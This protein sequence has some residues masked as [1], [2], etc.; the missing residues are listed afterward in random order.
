MKKRIMSLLLALLMVISV[1]PMPT[2][3]E[4]VT[5]SEELRCLCPENYDT[6]NGHVATCPLYTCP[7]CG[8]APW[9]ET[10]P[11]SGDIG[12]YAVLNSALSTYTAYNEYEFPYY[13]ED[14][15]ADTV[16]TIT[17]WRWD[18]EAKQ[19]WYQVEFYSGS[20]QGSFGVWNPGTWFL[21]NSESGDTL[22]FVEICEICGKP[23]CDGKHTQCGICG[24]YGCTELHFY[25]EHCDNYTCTEDHLICRAC[26]TPD[27]ETA[28][29]WCGICAEYDCGE[30]HVDAFKPVTAPIIPAS[31]AM[32]P[33]AEVS[34]ADENGNAVSSLILAPGQR[35][36]LS[37]WSAKGLSGVYQWQIRYDA[38]EDLWTNIQG[39]TGKGII[40]SPGLVNSVIS[41]SG[42]AALRC[43]ITSGDVTEVS[44]AIPVS[45]LYEPV[46]FSENGSASFPIAEEDDGDLLEDA[47]IVIQYV[48]SDGRTAASSDIAEVIPGVPANHSVP[49]PTIVGY[50]ATLENAGGHATIDGNTLNV[51][52]TADELVP[53][54]YQQVKVVYQPDYVKY[55]IIHYWQ[56]VENDR[57]SIKEREVV[58]F[59]DSDLSD[60]DRAHKTG[61]AIVSAHKN[62]PGFYHLLYETPAAAADG[63]TVIEVYYDR[64]YYLMKF[65]LGEDAYGVYPVYARYGDSLDEI[66]TPTRAGYTFMGWTLNGVDAEVPSTMP[67]ENRTYTAKWE[68]AGNVDYTIVYW[69]ENADNNGY[70]YWAQVPGSALPGT[71]VDGTNSIE[72][73][74]GIEDE[75]YFTYNDT[76]TDKNVVVKGD[77]STIVN[78]YYNRN[79]Y[80]I[81]FKGYGTCA[82]DAHSHGTGCNTPLICGLNGHTHS[83]ECERTLT[84]LIQEHVHGDACALQCGLPIH[85]DHGDACTI[86]EKELHPAHTVD[87]NCYTL[88]CDHTHSGRCYGSPGTDSPSS[89]R[90]NAIASRGGEPESGYVYA[91]RRSNSNGAWEYHLYLNGTWYDGSE[92]SRANDYTPWTGTS[93]GNTYSVRK[94][95]A[96]CEHS[97]SIENGCYDLTCTKPIHASHSE[98]EGCYSDVIHTGHTDECYGHAS[99]PHTEDCYYYECGET[100]HEHNSSCY[101]ECYLPVHSHSNTCNSNNSNNIIY[102][103]TAKYEQNVADIWP[104]YDLLKTLEEPSKTNSGDVVN[105]G[106]SKF[107]GWDIDIP[108]SEA[109]SKRVTMTADLCDTTDGEQNAVATYSANYFYRLYYMFESFDQTSG[110]DGNERR[111][112]DSANQGVTGKYYDSSA[113]YY[114]ELY[115]SSDTTFG[116]KQISG[117]TAVGTEKTTTG[118]SNNGSLVIYNFLY[119]T[120]NRH[121]LHFYN[122]NETVKTETDLMFGQP[123]KA[124]SGA[125]GKLVRNYVPPYPTDMEP[126]A[127]RFTGWYTSPECYEGT[128][129]NFDDLTMPNNDLTLYAKWEP[130]EY[131][132]NFFLDRD[133]MEARETIPE[134][135]KRLVN[136]AIE[137]GKIA[138]KPANDPYSVLYV[139]DIVKHG[140]FLGNP[141]D[142]DVAEGYEGI[143]PYTGY[144]FIGWFYLDD[145]GDEVAFDP[146]NIPVNRHLNLYAKWNANTLCAYNIYFAL[147]ENGDGVADTDDAGNIIYIADSITGSAIA[148]L[149]YTFNAK[150]G[151]D[152]Y[153]LGEGQNYRE[154]YFPAVSS[155]SLTLD[156]T[157][158]EGLGANRFTFLYR[159]KAAVPYVVKYIDKETGESLIPDKRVDNNRNVIVTENFI[160]QQGYMPEDYQISL[161]VTDDG[162]PDNDVIIF[163]YTKDEE[164]ALY[165]VNYYIQDLDAQLNHKGW[166]KYTDLQYTG[167]IGENYYADA[168]DIDGFTLS[169]DHTDKYNTVDKINGMS[170]MPLPSD[171]STITGGRITGELTGSG[172]ELNFY[173][174]RNLYPYEFRYMLDGTTIQLEEPTLGIGGYD[175]YVTGVAKEIVMDLDGDGVY[176]D[177]RLYDPTEVT[178]DIH[179]IPDGEAL[180]ADDVVVAG[181]A[182]VNLATF[183]YVRCTQTMTVTKNVVDMSDDSNPDP[184]TEFSLNLTIHAGSGYHRDSYSYTVSEGETEVRSGTLSPLPSAPNRIN[185][186][187]KDGQTITIDGLPTAEYSIDESNLPVG[188]YDDEYLPAI[189]NTLTVDGQLDVTVKN[190]YDP[191]TL[192]ISKTVDV[193][194]DNNNIPEVENFFFTVTVPSGVSGKYDYTVGGE[195]R[196]AE[197]IDGK[198]TL[199]LKNGEAALFL[200]LP[201]GIYTVEEEDYKAS[202]YN[203]YVSLNGAEHTEISVA[204]TE[205]VRG[206]DD[207]VN[208]RNM[209]PVGDLCIEKTVTK[210]FYGSVWNGDSFNFTVERTTA[211][212]PLITGNTY[213]VHEGGVKVGSATVDADGKMLVT[214]SFNADDAAKLDEAAEQGAEAVRSYVIKNVPAGEY[215]VVEAEYADYNQSERTVSGLSVPANT[216]PVARFTN[217]LIRL[218]GSLYLEK[219]LEIVDGFNGPEESIKFRFTVEL[220]ELVPTGNT[221]ITLTY[222]ANKYSD[223]EPTVATGVMKNGCFTVMLEAGMNV[224]IDGLP[225]GSYRII[226][227]TVPS[228][229]NNFAHRE[230]GAW[231]PKPTATTDDGRLCTD[232]VVPGEDVAEVKCTNTYPVDTAELVIQKLVTKNYDRDTL[233]E[234]TFVFT[235]TLAENNRDS[236]SYKIYNQNESVAVNNGTAAV[237]NKSFSIS[238]MAGQYAVIEDMPVCEYTVSENASAADYIGSYEVYLSECKN[239]PATEVNTNGEPAAS[240]EGFSFGRTFSAGKV[241][242]VVFTNEY[243]RHLGTLTITKTATGGN[244]DDTFLFHIKGA[245]TSNSYID[246]DVTIDGSGSVKIYDMPLGSYTVT[247]DS[248]W[249]W[250]WI[251]SS[252]PSGTEVISTDDLHA[253]IAFENSFDED[254]WLNGT[255]CRPN[256][257]GKKDND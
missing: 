153:N 8:G 44:A 38:A 99:H 217:E 34:I 112:Y 91:T 139:E 155:H 247:E 125:D 227:E 249:S 19:L 23:N 138:A 47:Y 5:G 45:F 86:C 97:H 170:R 42:S 46:F 107:R 164:H 177:Y 16:F 257:F 178:K 192:E 102:V 161:I 252:A 11:Y 122:V 30:T 181:Q 174:T 194:E 74:N 25:C 56:N 207:S 179:I 190:S 14:F 163:Y 216:A 89:N 75:K 223:D 114:Q 24:N 187:L 166:T 146:L 116:Q 48:Y 141:G 222:S 253:E 172:M 137:S 2:F 171:V 198:M 184:D 3:A 26:G 109:V 214:I 120:R 210:E 233:P 28:H 29:I 229:A 176:E 83:S 106:G 200:N 143:H 127:Y 133:S 196:T 236:Y 156:I 27:C 244:A 168:V 221:A 80:T 15:T 250:R 105:S 71:T 199:S 31:P 145:D 135:M 40:V 151:E 35:V 123:L 248:S 113:D 85:F 235:V 43:V 234:D 165:V 20:T 110:A 118:S 61:E 57:Y 104:T 211:G 239:D 37:A 245:D 225:E 64:Y 206:D 144:E 142:P 7:E 49:V 215:S 237:S 148:G 58:D 13:P 158:T 238:L 209:Y 130:V 84:C 1:L 205:L 242:T 101:R 226:E 203:S 191:A 147:D 134:E 212:R 197:V 55:T 152:L 224:R 173:Y 185:F 6:T 12:K 73:V 251:C 124:Y 204:E 36:S 189:R 66:G 219:E 33:G 167:T 79:Y 50:K 183:Y 53:G 186:S 188:Y 256:V 111:Y 175:T 218:N 121:D 65:D 41:A 115:Y 246:M 10:C 98:A 95:A 202:G 87:G 90:R 140:G 255:S 128:E 149:T 54:E 213:D 193:V 136:E 77:G 162:N 62:Y 180:D 154:G 60:N 201:L 59:Y 51:S 160:P 220:Q 232:I 169:T 243:R 32:T 132:V 9:H 18:T 208:F 240:G 103:L 22:I 195:S 96:L 4:G 17:A 117:M 126:N 108:T 63:S 131:K 93:G 159:Q 88:D 150:G 81:Y 230:N 94:Y 78:V 100:P 182:K 69:K 157:D 76:L 92:V 72:S 82:M 119:Y 129:A 241:E 68:P 39:Q 254:R 231:V 52:F 70:S 21:Q 228:Y 67:A